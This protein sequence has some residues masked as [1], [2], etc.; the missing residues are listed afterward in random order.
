MQFMNDQEIIIFYFLQVDNIGFLMVPGF[1]HHK[2][3]LLLVYQLLWTNWM[4][5]LSGAKTE[6]LTSSTRIC[7][8]G[9]VQRTK[10][11]TRVILKTLS[12]IG[13]EFREILMQL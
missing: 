3:F 10:P 5:Y 8:G 7:I 11:W 13:E 6:K 1:L 12:E 2:T 9:S 4:M